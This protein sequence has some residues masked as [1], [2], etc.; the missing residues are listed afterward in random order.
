MV[1][2][3]V[4]A[5]TRVQLQ[6]HIKMAVQQH[7]VKVMLVVEVIEPQLL[8]THHRVV[9]AVREWLVQTVLVLVLL[10]FLATEAMV[11]HHL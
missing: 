8:A 2:L 5:G 9:V 1:V 6:T 10:Q 3:V 11:L 4:V 7:L